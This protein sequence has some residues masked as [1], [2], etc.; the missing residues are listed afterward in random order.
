MRPRLAGLTAA[1]E[2]GA[3]VAG[4]WAKART[5]P[6]EAV[7]AHVRNRAAVFVMLV[8]AV[9]QVFRGGTRG[10]VPRN[11]RYFEALA[12]T[13]RYGSGR[14]PNATLIADAPVVYLEVLDLF[15]A[16][17]GPEDDTHRRRSRRR[18]VRVGGGSGS[19][20]ATAP[21]TWGQCP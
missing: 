19:S 3:S 18:L 8:I 17:P 7:N 16:V 6:R 15:D 5:D 20:C 21:F 14:N 13:I 12:R 2:A 11:L 4:A 1:A 9:L 10:A